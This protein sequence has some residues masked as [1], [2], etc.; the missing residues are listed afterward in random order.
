MALA[1][2]LGIAI[3]LD[4]PPDVLSVSEANRMLGAVR[5]AYADTLASDRHPVLF[6]DIGCDPRSVDVNVHPAKSEVR[7]RD[8]GLVREAGRLFPGQ[9]AV[10]IDAKDGRVAVEGWAEVSEP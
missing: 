2:V 4:S 8:P 3:A 7:F 6:L 1:A 9:V 10:G 5:G